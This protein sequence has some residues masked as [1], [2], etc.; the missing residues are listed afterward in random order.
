MLAAAPSSSM[1]QYTPL[2]IGAG[3]ILAVVLLAK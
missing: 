2:I 3:V 1:A